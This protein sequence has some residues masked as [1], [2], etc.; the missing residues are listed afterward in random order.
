[1]VVIGF[2]KSA[3]PSTEQIK[4]G[5]QGINPQQVKFE[6]YEPKTDERAKHI[7]DFNFW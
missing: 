1:M 2:D 4:E 5:K 3:N 7:R 6:I